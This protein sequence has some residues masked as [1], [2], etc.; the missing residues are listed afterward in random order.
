MAYF[1]ME[2]SDIGLI[3]LLQMLCVILSG[4]VPLICTV[5]IVKQA[6]LMLNMGSIVTNVP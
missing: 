1:F 4:N 3:F 5:Y 2:K 6:C